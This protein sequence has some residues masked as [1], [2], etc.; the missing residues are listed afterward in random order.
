MKSVL[1]L[2]IGAMLI[3][4]GSA[5]QTI[6][7]DPNVELRP[8][9]GFHAIEVSD[10]ISLYLSQGD[11]ETVAVSAINAKWRDHIRTEVKDGVL[12]I[13]LDTRGWGND[14]K[15]KAYISFTMLDKLYASGA[16]NV[17][18]DGVISGNTL[19]L[20]LSGASN[21][22]GAVHLNELFLDQSGASDAVI[23]GSVA[24]RTTIHASG[25]SDV[26]GYELSTQN[27]DVHASGASDIHI[28][29]NKELNAHATGA[30]S[31]HYKGDAVVGELHSSGASS[32]SKKG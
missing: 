30:S 10:A 15:L 18:V 28:T 6:I 19:D 4:N 8:V 32:V 23:T 27:C 29:V 31:V 26:K 2:I 21:F 25:A 24:S 22:K 20:G 13:W 1:F 12:K 7:H 11:Q 17:Y 16:S 14:K 9:K 5:Q 3:M